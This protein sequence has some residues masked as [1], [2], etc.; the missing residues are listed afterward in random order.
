MSTPTPFMQCHS[1]VLVGNFNP[2]I[3]HPAWFKAHKL[4][5]E[6]EA[7]EAEI[8]IIHRDIVIFSLE[9]LKLQV[10]S[11]RFLVRT[12]QE[13]YFSFLYDLVLS[14]FKLLIHTPVR[15]MGINKEM[16]FSMDTE[17]KWHNAGHVLAPKELWKDILNNP[18]MRKLTMQES[19]QRDGLQ[20]I[21]TVSVEPS[22]VIKPGIFF[23]VNDHFQVKNKKDAIGCEEILEILDKQWKVSVERSD[24]MI[25][26]LMEKL[27]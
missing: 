21:V 26:K 18:G 27:S 1:I 6:K 25:Y 24:G 19:K 13:P 12:T 9:W 11:D 8:E 22:P 23:S 2:L 17:E 15:M 10:T 4:I 14:A 5:M 3:F 20:G 7:D 16:H